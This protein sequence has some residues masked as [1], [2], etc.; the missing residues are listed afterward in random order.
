LYRLVSPD[1]CPTIAPTVA[2]SAT[3]TATPAPIETVPVTGPISAPPSKSPTTNQPTAMGTPKERSPFRSPQVMAA[4]TRVHYLNTA[5]TIKPFTWKTTQFEF[6]TR[7][8]NGNVPGPTLSVYPG[9]TMKYAL[10][11][12]LVCFFFLPCFFF[13]L[14]SFVICFVLQSGME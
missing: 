4:N 6:R 3:P 9:V 11:V 14:A 8:Y 10:L 5:L 12:F 7:A 1:K 2:P 13:I